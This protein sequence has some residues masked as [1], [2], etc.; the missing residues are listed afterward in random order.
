MTSLSLITSCRNAVDLLPATL[1]SIRQQSL[2]LGRDARFEYIVV[3]GASTDGTVDLIRSAAAE[4]PIRLISEP[5]R[6]VYDGLAKG[7]AK[8]SGDVVGYLNAGDRLFP[9]ALETLRDAFET[10]PASWMTGY[11]TLA[12]AKGQPWRVNL[13]FRFRPQ[14]FS[15]GLHGT[16]LLTLQQESTFWR[17]SL[18]QGLNWDRFR[19][20][21]LAG[22]FYLWQHFS[23]TEPPAILHSLIGTFCA[24]PNQLSADNSQYVAE[25]KSLCRAPRMSEWMV[26]WTDRFFWKAPRGVKRR[27]GG[28]RHIVYDP[29]ADSWILK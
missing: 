28:G 23:K 9:T 16:F 8:A 15:N 19:S 3:D 24:H 6:G 14:F 2:L 7:F 5:D 17:R 1:R 18:L 27:L 10:T 25:L 29:R 11:S 13:P 4:L 12:N 20:L 21:K 26:A 22:D